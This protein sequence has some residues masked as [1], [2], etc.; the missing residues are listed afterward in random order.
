MECTPEGRNA[1]QSLSWVEKVLRS[2]NCHEHSM[3]VSGLS[4]NIADPFPPKFN[5]LKRSQGVKV[6]SSNVMLP[7]PPPSNQHKRIEKAAA[8]AIFPAPTQSL[9]KTIKIYLSEKFSSFCVWK[10]KRKISLDVTE[11]KK[12]F[13][14]GRG[15]LPRRDVRCVFVLV[16]ISEKQQ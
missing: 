13:C 6:H 11:K 14:E 5:F 7:A 3:V 2:S 10:D 8:T 12:F 1:N 15:E 16:A 9:Q 4:L